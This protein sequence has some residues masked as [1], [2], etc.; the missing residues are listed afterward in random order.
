MWKKW[1]PL[2]REAH[3]KVK[4]VKSGRVLSTMSTII[5]ITNIIRIIIVTTI[6]II[7][8]AIIIVIII[9]IITIT[10]IIKI[11]TT[12]IMNIIIVLINN[13]II[14]YPPTPPGLFGVSC[15]DNFKILYALKS[16][17]TVL[18]NIIMYNQYC[19]NTVQTF[20]PF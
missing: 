18:H 15:R 11:A 9:I 3:F 2:W 6:V 1:T 16:P 4:R 7:I 10:V 8:I 17:Q 12:I 5:T 13:I 14:H 19:C 20:Q